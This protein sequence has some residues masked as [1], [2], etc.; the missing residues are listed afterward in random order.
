MDN[1]VNLHNHSQYSILDGFGSLEEYI[2]RAY[3]LKQPAIGLTD[4]GSLCGV[5]DF[6][7]KCKTFNEKG[8]TNSSGK[9]IKPDYPMKAVAGLEAYVAPECSEKDLQLDPHTGAAHHKPVFYSDNISLRKY[10][11]SG[12]GAYLHMTLF[13]MNYKGLQSLF[14]LM[15]EASREGNSFNHLNMPDGEGN[16]YQK[17]RID[18]S[19]LEKYNEGLIATTGCP[20]GEIQTRFRLG[21]DDKAYDYAR[22]MK[23][24]FG[25]RY[26]VEIMNHH[27]EHNTIET[28]VIPK[29]IKLSDDL[30]IPLLATNDSHYSKAED[31]PHHEEMLCANSGACMTDPTYDEDAGDDYKGKKRFSFNGDQYY[32]KSS[33]EMQTALIDESMSEHVKTKMLEAIENS[34]KLAERVENI[35]FSLRDDLRPVVKIPEGYTE[36]TWFKQKIA[37]GFAEKRKGTDEATLK[38]S[39]ERV[40]HEFPVFAENN[41]IQYMLVVQDYINHARS[42]GIPVGFGRGSV[43]GSEIAYLMNISDTDPIRHDLMF[44]RFLNPERLSPP[45]V[46]TDFGAARRDEVVDYVKNKYGESNVANI[47]TFNKFLSKTAVMDMARIY[48]VSIPETLKVTNLMPMVSKTAACEL[49]D[50]LGYDRLSDGKPYNN[51][52][53]SSAQAKEFREA[54]IDNKDEAKKEL[55]TKVIDAAKAIENRIKTTGVHA[56]GIIISDKPIIEVAPMMYKHN[57][58]KPWGSSICQWPYEELEAIGLIKMDFLALSDLDIVAETLKNIKHTKG[59]SLNM[60][61]IVHGSMDD[62]ETY[63]TLQNGQTESVFQLSSKGMKSLF[64]RMQPTKFEDIQASVALYRPGPMGMDAHTQYADRSS[65]KTPYTVIN[66]DLNKTFKNT[67]VDELLKNTQGLVLYQEEVMNISRKLC[68]FTWGEAD[69]LRKGMGHKKMDLLEQMEPK[70]INGALEYFKKHGK[71]YDGTNL[72]KAQIDHNDMIYKNVK[73]LWDYLKKFGEYGFNASHAASYA[74]VSY[75]TAFLKTHY[76]A[77]FMAAVT[78]DKIR[79]SKTVDDVRKA[80]REARNM[81]LKVG[82]LDINNS[83]V[84]VSAVKKHSNNDPDIVFG[85]SGIKGVSIQ[86]AKELVEARERYNKEFRNF[87]DFMK[88]LPSS[89]INKKLI[90]GLALGGAFDCLNIT[91][92]SIYSAIPSIIKSYKNEAKHVENG[93]VSV[94]DMLEDF[95]DDSS[96]SQKTQSEVIN[97]PKLKEWNWLRKLSKEDKTLGVVVSGT[98]MERL[99]KGY[100]F[101]RNVLKMKGYTVKTIKELCDMKE[102]SIPAFSFRNKLDNDKYMIKI[103]CDLANIEIFKSKN[104]NSKNIVGVIE[105]NDASIPFKVNKEGFKK[106]GDKIALFDKEGDVAVK[107]M[108]KKKNGKGETALYRKLSEAESFNLLKKNYVYIVTGIMSK[109]YNNEKELIVTDFN[110]LKVMDNGELPIWVHTPFH[111]TLNKIIFNIDDVK[112]QFSDDGKLT[113]DK[114]LDMILQYKK[115]DED[116]ISKYKDALSNFKGETPVIMEVPVY[117]EIISQITNNRSIQDSKKCFKNVIISYISFNDKKITNVFETMGR[118]NLGKKSW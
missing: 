60:R 59:I 43:G 18:I 53:Y 91:R 44:E 95:S 112:S 5:Y 79:K 16:Y 110:E 88:A 105:D 47:I 2:L 99:G 116:F 29:L 25:D 19:M 40:K 86:T 111:E 22:R 85:I 23:G 9:V 31:A 73:S 65:G 87:N 93:M 108:V 80:L 115:Q 58:S 118:N 11:V 42:K 48:G 104:G 14:K 67:P 35:N 114:I 100:N 49:H 21:Q 54:T 33:Q 41:F 90:E 82:A 75:E 117:D 26:Y 13:A 74:L 36:E 84:E 20:S 12:S 52:I 96:E 64:R 51:D 4:H 56:C 8:L 103:I 68:G 63:K 30:N 70:F 62:T 92:N 55:W 81:G 83:G 38:E 66:D 98:P 37:E 15:N 45:D 46:D 102:D 107:T 28:D 34:V 94:F 106:Y 78:T 3:E 109:N 17:P 7:Q 77:E 61:E 76:P 89:L 113:E 27:M 71:Y 101:T 32:L 39:Q 24:I 6:I 69:A 1:F 10:D 50:I 97:I 57:P 72:N